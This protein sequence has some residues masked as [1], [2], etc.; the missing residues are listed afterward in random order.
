[1]IGHLVPEH[2][3]VSVEMSVPEYAVLSGM[4]GLAVAVMQRDQEACMAFMRELSNPACEAFAKT[5]M[6][7]F[8]EITREYKNGGL[9][10]INEI[11]S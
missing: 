11:V 7:G 6:E 8:A 10:P 4:V 2:H 9:E 5:L 1:M 3:E